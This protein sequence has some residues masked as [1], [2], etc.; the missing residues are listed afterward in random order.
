MIL[1]ARLRAGAALSTFGF[2]LEL[3][4]TPPDPQARYAS[5]GYHEELIRGTVT[6]AAAAYVRTFVTL[7]ILLLVPGRP[8]R[9]EMT[10]RMTLSIA[11][12]SALVSCVLAG[13]GFKVDTSNFRTE[14][15][16]SP[17]VVL[18]EFFSPRRG[19][20]V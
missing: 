10:P 18:L 3:G 16:D 1:G 19:I 8:G 6:S 4:F 13:T 9:P 20:H 14:V 2:P 11:L 15:V 5:T 17:N 7:C 12:I